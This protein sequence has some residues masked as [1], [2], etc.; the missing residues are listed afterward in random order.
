M[1]EDR[2][3]N[4]RKVCLYGGWIVLSKLHSNSFYI[5]QVILVQEDYWLEWKCL[6]LVFEDKK[7]LLEFG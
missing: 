3:L 2:T 4:R 6:Y 1:D 5:T 7:M